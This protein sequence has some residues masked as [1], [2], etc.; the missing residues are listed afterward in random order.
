[1]KAENGEK[2]VPITWAYNHHCEA[3]ITGKYYKV[4][5]QGKFQDPK[6]NSKIPIY[7]WFAE[8]NGGEYR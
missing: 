7:Q 4:T 6:P 1:M 5:H 8:G 3:Y 2:F